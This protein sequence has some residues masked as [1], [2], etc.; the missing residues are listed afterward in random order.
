MFQPLVIDDPISIKGVILQPEHESIITN[1]SDI[2]ISTPCQVSEINQSSLVVNFMPQKQLNGKCF[3]LTN[4]KPFQFSS[5]NKL[6]KTVCKVF[7]K[8]G[9]HLTTTMNQIIQNSY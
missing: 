1:Q 8:V 5:K 3:T 4:R 9:Q 7:V 6:F 2:P